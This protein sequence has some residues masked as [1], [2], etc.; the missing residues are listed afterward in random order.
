MLGCSCQRSFSIL[1]CNTKTAE[2]SA[3]FCNS[4]RYKLLLR[5]RLGL[6]LR[7]RS[8]LHSPLHPFLHLLLHGCVFLLL[9]II[10]HG[11]NLACS[12]VVQAFCFCHLVIAR[13]RCV[14][15]NLHHLLL[16]IFKNWLDLGLLIRGQVEGFRKVLQLL[17]RIHHLMTRSMHWG[18]GGCGGGLVLRECHSKCE[19]ASKR[20]RTEYF[21]H[22]V[23]F[24]PTLIQTPYVVR[25]L[26]LPQ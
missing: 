7:C 2:S 4:L 5:L 3:V 22:N 21:S 26:R 15:M 8:T 19:Q 14:L 10:Q 16:L 12:V 9:L 1:K 25:G 17:V 6:R 24:P 11:F 20:Y 13:E 18:S 23:L